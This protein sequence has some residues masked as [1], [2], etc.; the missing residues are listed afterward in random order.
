MVLRSRGHLLNVSL[1]AE[2]GICDLRHMLNNPGVKDYQF[3]CIYAVET[4]I[5]EHISPGKPETIVNVFLQ[6]IFKRPGSIMGFVIDEG[7][8]YDIGSVEE[9]NRLRARMDDAGK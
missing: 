6:R 1:N 8:W 5:L 3:A 9:Y 4:S 2:N 7:N